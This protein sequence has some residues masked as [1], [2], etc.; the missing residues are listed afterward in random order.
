MKLMVD[1]TETVSHFS[2]DPNLDVKG[3]LFPLQ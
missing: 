1:A 2:G 3:E